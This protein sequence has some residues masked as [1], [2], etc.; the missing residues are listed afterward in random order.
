MILQKTSK[1]KIPSFAILNLFSSFAVCKLTLAK[2]NSFKESGP[3]MTLVPPYNIRTRFAA[4]RFAS[5][6]IEFVFLVGIY[7]GCQAQMG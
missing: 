2:L 6:R 7:L 4:V 1:A 3:F 5:T